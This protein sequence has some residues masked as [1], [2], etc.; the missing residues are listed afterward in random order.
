MMNYLI[1]WSFSSILSWSNITLKG[2]LG[3]PRKL[4]TDAVKLLCMAIQKNSPDQPIKF[5]L[6]T[7]TAN[8]N[9]DLNEPVSIGEKIV[10]GLIRLLVHHNPT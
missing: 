10:M 3:K 4:V 7:Q 1:D 8:R 5:V 2:I 9:R 6:M